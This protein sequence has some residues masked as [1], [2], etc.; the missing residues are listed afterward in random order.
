[1]IDSVD[2]DRVETSKNEMLAMLQEDDLTGVPLLILANK[3]D[4]AGAMSEVELSEA[5]GLT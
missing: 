3:Q 1:V 2:R 5:M 4:V